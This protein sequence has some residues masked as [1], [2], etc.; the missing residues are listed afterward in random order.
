VFSNQNYPT[1]RVGVGNVFLEKNQYENQSIKNYHLELSEPL[2]NYLLY[3]VSLIYSSTTTKNSLLDFTQKSYA[4]RKAFGF[5]MTYLF[6]YSFL[7]GFSTLLKSSVYTGFNKKMKIA[8]ISF[9]LF[10]AFT[11]DYAISK[12]WLFSFKL[13]KDLEINE[14]EASDFLEFSLG[15][16]M[17]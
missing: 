11:V 13:G 6:R 3:D 2:S 15:Y 17:K 10:M 16:F 1:I 14:K 9:P 8:N 5:Q 12:D 4:F 7:F